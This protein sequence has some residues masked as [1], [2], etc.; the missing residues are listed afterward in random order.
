MFPNSQSIETKFYLLSNLK[1][2]NIFSEYI[3]T[4]KI[5]FTNYYG[6]DI[7]YPINKS[8][9]KSLN[10]ISRNSIRPLNLFSKTNK[11]KSNNKVVSVKERIRLYSKP[12]TISKGLMVKLGLD[13]SDKKNRINIIKMDFPYC[14]PSVKNSFTE[15][16]KKNKN[17]DF[18]IA[19]KLKK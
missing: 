16:I 2:R 12:K 1:K 10:I 4:Q 17:R 19:K 9:N 13:F 8:G 11:S 18:I 7:K 14:K 6:E 15:L 5:G 3:R